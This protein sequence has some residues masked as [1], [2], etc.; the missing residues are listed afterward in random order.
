MI[1]VPVIEGSFGTV[2]SLRRPWEMWAAVYQR[3]HRLRARQGAR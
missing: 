3:R 1:R 2:G